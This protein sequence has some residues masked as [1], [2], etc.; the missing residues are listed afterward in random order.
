MAI[1]LSLLCEFLV[2]LRLV[3]GNG[4]VVAFVLEDLVCS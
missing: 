3:L 1:L 4:N 2:V